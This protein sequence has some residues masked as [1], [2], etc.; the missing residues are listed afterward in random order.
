M[1]LMIANHDILFFVV[2]RAKEFLEK[3]NPNHSAIRVLCMA[4]ISFMFL[5]LYI[6]CRAVIIFVSTV[7]RQSLLFARNAIPPCFFS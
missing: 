3:Q 7:L 5:T 6:S 2:P 4:D 1:H